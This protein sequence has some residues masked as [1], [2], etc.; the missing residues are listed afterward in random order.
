M[1]RLAIASALVL[2]LSHTFERTFVQSMIPAFGAAILALDGNFTLLGIDISR[3]D[4]PNETLRIRANLAHPIK[5]AGRTLLPFGWGPMPEGG[6]QLTLALGGVL[7]YCA[8]MLIVVLA[9]P[10][11][12]AWEFAL[13]ILIA[14]PLMAILLLIDVPFTVLAE[15]WGAIHRNI[16]PQIFQPLMIWSRF[17]MGGG[18][19]VLALLMAGIAIGLGARW[20]RMRDSHR[21]SQHHPEIA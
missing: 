20:S 11:M 9:W 6:F 1:V 17:L 5:V 18:G 13:R 4:G 3:D 7:Q 19:L 8:L 14:A 16:D 21:P 2:W 12:R 10:A 15:L